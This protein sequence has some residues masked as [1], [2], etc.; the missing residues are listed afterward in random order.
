M[1]PC[2][3]GRSSSAKVAALDGLPNVTF[4]APDI[5]MQASSVS[6][7]IGGTLDYIV[8]NAGN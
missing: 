8:T 4:M 1:R 3:R 6:K 2:L 5:T 7:E